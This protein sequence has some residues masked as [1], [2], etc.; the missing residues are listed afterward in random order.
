MYWRELWVLW[1]EG[2]PSHY[3]N[4]PSL[5]TEDD[6]RIHRAPVWRRAEKEER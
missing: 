1:S 2:R 5:K 3:P 6:Q 4:D